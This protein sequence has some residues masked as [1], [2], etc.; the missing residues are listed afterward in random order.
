MLR[1]SLCKDYTQIIDLTQVM[2]VV[3]SA[4]QVKII[5]A[6]TSNN[7]RRRKPQSS[8]INCKRNAKHTIMQKSFPACAQHPL[9]SP[10][11]QNR[12][13]QRRKESYEPL[14][15]QGVGPGVQKCKHPLSGAQHLS[16]SS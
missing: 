14:H 12:K 1:L 6:I 10:Y 2:S 13:C 4:F 3:H 11:C 16:W 8:Y 9:W 15:K 7:H 5:L